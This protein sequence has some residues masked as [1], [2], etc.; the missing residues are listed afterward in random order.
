MRRL[1]SPIRRL[2]R[3]HPLQSWLLVMAVIVGL[4]W[5]GL[6]PLALLVAVVWTVYAVYTWLSPSWRRRS[7]RRR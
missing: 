6:R 4:S 3:L 5:I 1:L 7:R 2:V